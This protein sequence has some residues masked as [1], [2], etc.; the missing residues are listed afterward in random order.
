M[1]IRHTSSQRYGLWIL[2][3]GLVTMVFSISL[4]SSSSIAPLVVV[5]SY[6]QQNEKIQNLSETNIPKI[7]PLAEVSLM[8]MRYSILQQK[9]P[10]KIYQTYGLT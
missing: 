8:V 3:I 6:A 4:F 5:N 1:A 7:L 2:A 10:I 9:Y